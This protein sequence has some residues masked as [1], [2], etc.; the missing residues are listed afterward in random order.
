MAHRSHRPH[1]MRRYICSRAPVNG[2]SSVLDTPQI[3]SCPVQAAAAST[4]TSSMP[5]SDTIRRLFGLS[6]NATDHS[7]HP[8]WSCGIII[9]PTC[10]LA[11]PNLRLSKAEL[12]L[13]SL[14][15]VCSVC[16]FKALCGP[17]ARQPQ[18]R[19]PGSTISQRRANTRR[20][21]HSLS[22]KCTC[23]TKT[24][25]R[26]EHALCRDCHPL[27]VS[28]MWKK[29]IKRGAIAE[30]D[31]LPASTNAIMQDTTSSSDSEEEG[32]DDDSSNAVDPDIEATAGS[33]G[34]THPTRS[35]FDPGG[36]QK[37]TPATSIHH[38]Y[39]C[40]QHLWILP[41]WL[42]FGKTR[43]LRWWRCRRCGLEARDV[44][45]SL[46]REFL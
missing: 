23:T 43:G 13:H 27:K 5:L 21:F 9:C 8:C 3:P 40:H 20:V 29:R 7:S 6:E 41:A 14:E 42:G 45:M 16:Y 31:E 35:D 46:R 12:R 25:P 28:E 22:A 24:P 26:L 33:A 10:S 19:W 30:A 18:R 2:L 37:P 15:P 1:A 36:F 11:K 32:T 17:Y 44:M 4:A 38:C 34:P 39:A